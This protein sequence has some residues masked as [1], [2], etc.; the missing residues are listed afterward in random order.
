[1][2]I[3]RTRYKQGTIRQRQTATGCNWVHRYYDQERKLKQITFDSR[4]I[5]RKRMWWK[6]TERLRHDLNAGT[7]YSGVE[8]INISVA[9]DQ[10]LDSLTGLKARTLR[11]ELRQLPLGLRDKFGTLLQSEDQHPLA[12]VKIP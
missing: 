12:I 8:R 2:K 3:S 6:A 4:T 10:W 9:L 5:R 11:G 1:M 7:D